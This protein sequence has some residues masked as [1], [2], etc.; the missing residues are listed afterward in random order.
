M[1]SRAHHI[2]DHF[3]HIGERPRR[4]VRYPG[5][6][7]PIELPGDRRG[8]F[9]GALL[10]SALIASSLVAGGVYALYAAGTSP[11]ARTEAAPLVPSWHLNVEPVLAQNQAL[12]AGPAHAV[13]S[14]ESQPGPEQPTEAPVVVGGD[15]GPAPVSP[16]TTPAVPPA[17]EP[18]V[19]EA[20]RPLPYPD[21][22]TTPP[23]AIAP[24]DV[25]PQG[26]TPLLDPENPYR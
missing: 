5:R 6:E 24:P 26:P 21:P 3:G 7:D 22:T 8:T 18:D 2:Q 15:R 9:S 12:I 19:T 16:P 20:P 11:L 4:A 25:G 23:D 10:V 13:P 17:A 14:V 1:A